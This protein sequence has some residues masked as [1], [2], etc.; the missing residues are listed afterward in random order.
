MRK[1][2]DTEAMTD[3]HDYTLIMDKARNR[4]VDYAIWV[5]DESEMAPATGLRDNSRNFNRALWDLSN[6][7]GMSRHC[8]NDLVGATPLHNG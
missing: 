7:T 8:G 6:A 1:G 3:S 4:A 2:I 5:R